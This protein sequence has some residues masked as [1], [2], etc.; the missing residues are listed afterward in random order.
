M[1]PEARNGFRYEQELTGGKVQRQSDSMTEL[2][3]GSPRRETQDCYG[4]GD[5]LLAEPESGWL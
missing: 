1:V 3:Q 4:T 5:H 2:A